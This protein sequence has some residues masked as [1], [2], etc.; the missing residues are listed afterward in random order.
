[1]RRSVDPRLGKKVFVSL[2]LHRLTLFWHHQ[3]PEWR[4]IN[5]K[6]W[7]LSIIRLYGSGL[8]AYHINNST[9]ALQYMYEVE[10]TEANPPRQISKKRERLIVYHPHAR[11]VQILEGIISLTLHVISLCLHVAHTTRNIH[12]EC[13]CLFAAYGAK[14]EGVRE[15]AKHSSIFFRFSSHFSSYSWHTT[16]KNRSAVAGTQP[17]VAP[18]GITHGTSVPPTN[19]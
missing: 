4:F 1:M 14:V 12:N 15:T 7:E 10:W 8:P 13:T 16:K 9:H 19:K 5:K 18:I 17:W 3:F 2:L 6:A 11:I